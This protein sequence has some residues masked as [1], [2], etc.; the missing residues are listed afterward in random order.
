MGLRQNGVPAKK[1]SSFLSPFS[2]EMEG[3]SVPRNWKGVNR[4]K[5]SSP[6]VLNERPWVVGSRGVW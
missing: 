5:V 4:A 2:P 1:P 3:C 6:L